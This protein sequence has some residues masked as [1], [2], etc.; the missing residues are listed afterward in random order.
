MKQAC[1][2]CQVITVD[3][4]ETT[5]GTLKPEVRHLPYWFGLFF[6]LLNDERDEG[7]RIYP[8]RLSENSRF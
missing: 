3:V 1:Y 5:V 8:P 6:L 4:N 7:L 2:C